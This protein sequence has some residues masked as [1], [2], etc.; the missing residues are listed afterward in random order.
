M[1]VNKEYEKLTDFRKITEE[2]IENSE[3]EIDYIYSSDEEINS[4]ILKENKKS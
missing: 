3:D 1:K 2:K 4:K